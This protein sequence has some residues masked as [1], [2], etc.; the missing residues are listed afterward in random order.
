M[1]K[2][3]AHPNFMACSRVVGENNVLLSSTRALWVQF[4]EFSAEDHEVL[5]SYGCELIE[6]N[7]CCQQL[8]TI[9][10]HNNASRIIHCLSQLQKCLNSVVD[11]VN[12]RHNAH[13]SSANLR[14]VLSVAAREGLGLDPNFRYTPGDCMFDT[15]KSVSG[16]YNTSKELRVISMNQFS[17]DLQQ[18]QQQAIIASQSLDLPVAEYIRR[19]KISA[20]DNRDESLWGDSVAL[21]YLCKAKRWNVRVWSAQASCVIHEI[22][23]NST[24]PRQVYNILLHKLHGAIDHYEPLVNLTA[25]HHDTIQRTDVVIPGAVYTDG[26]NYTAKT[27]RRKTKRAAPEESKIKSHTNITQAEEERNTFASVVQQQEYEADLV[28]QISGSMDGVP[29]PTSS[30]QIN[31]VSERSKDE[32]HSIMTQT[33]EEDNTITSLVQEQ[34]NEADLQSEISGSVDKLLKPTSSEQMNKI[35]H[36][37]PS[38]IWPTPSK[39][40]TSMSTE[41]VDIISVTRSIMNCM[42]G[43]INNWPTSIDDDIRKVIKDL[44]L[45]ATIYDRSLEILVYNLEFFR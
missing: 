40:C 41:V 15:L 9:A 2:H 19:M 23:F 1:V 25:P 32:S 34:E 28:S 4:S 42:H 3:I 30:E 37:V 18:K 14:S 6:I 12:S 5:R 17:S 43:C 24:E 11:L 27:R 21:L 45:Y 26:D 22:N 8:N 20:Y 33:E 38:V 36:M 7:E 13:E 44:Y 29:E 39:M 10:A 16:C 31:E 35:H